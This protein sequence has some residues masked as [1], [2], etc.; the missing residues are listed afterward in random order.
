MTD[1]TMRAMH[2]GLVSG[3]LATVIS[4]IGDHIQRNSSPDGQGHVYNYFFA[5]GKKTR[6]LCRRLWQGVTA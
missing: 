1:D 4:L 6:R 3:G 2:N 5:L